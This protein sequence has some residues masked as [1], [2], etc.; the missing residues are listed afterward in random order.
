MK[1]YSLDKNGQANWYSN[2]TEYLNAIATPVQKKAY[3]MYGWNTFMSPFIEDKD[4]EFVPFD[5][6]KYQ[7]ATTFD[8]SSEYV[9]IEEKISEYLNRQIPLI[10]TAKNEDDFSKL[11]SETIKNAYSLGQNELIN[12]YNSNLS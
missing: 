7:I 5:I 2:S 1:L 11:L 10:V 6:T 12:E 9:V 3:S 4:I 8:S